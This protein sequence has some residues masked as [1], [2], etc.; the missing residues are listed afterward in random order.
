M[1]SPPVPLFPLLLLPPNGSVA[2]GQ[3][4]AVRF[5]GLALEAGPNGSACDVE[6]RARTLL[7]SLAAAA[8]PPSSPVHQHPDP[9]RRQDH[10]RRKDRRFVRK[11]P[12]LRRLLLLLSPSATTTSA[13][14]TSAATTSAARSAARRLQQE[15]GN[16]FPCLQIVAS[17]PGEP[18]PTGWRVVRSV[19]RAPASGWVV[20]SWS[21]HSRSPEK[22]EVYQRLQREMLKCI[23]RDVDGYL[24][25]RGVRQGQ[26]GLS[27]TFFRDRAAL[28]AWRTHPAHLRTKRASVALGMY[29]EY[30]ICVARVDRRYGFRAKKPTQ[31]Q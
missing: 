2:G 31:E 20:S 7:A 30:E 18:L 8:T 29:D 13:A 14:T 12:P 1:P 17:R 27:L 19:Y 4:A 28:E 5:G 21:R 10:P 15:F 16:S 9:D 25:R 26:E 23:E 6:D 11:T 22:E 3:D 24:G